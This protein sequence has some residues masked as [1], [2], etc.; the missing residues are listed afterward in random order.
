MTD[1][2]TVGLLGVV[3][4]FE[5]AARRVV[6]ISAACVIPLHTLIRGDGRVGYVEVR[7]DIWIARNGN[8]SCPI[9]EVV[10]VLRPDNVDECR[11]ISCHDW[12]G[13]CG[14]G[15]GGRT[16]HDRRAS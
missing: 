3:I 6:Q 15:S 1:V 16:G 5:I 14:G 2:R 7:I 12:R 11:T 8:R 4:D 10:G 13:S 9:G